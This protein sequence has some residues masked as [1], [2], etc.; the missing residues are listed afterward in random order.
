MAR[1][2]L[3]QQLAELSN[4]APASELDPEAEGDDKVGQ[5]GEEGREHYEDVG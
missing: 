1:L 5:A 2:S 3:A 4:A